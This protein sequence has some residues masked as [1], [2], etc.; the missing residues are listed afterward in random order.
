MGYAV[1][2]ADIV[3]LYG[4]QGVV[5]FPRDT[6]GDPAAEL[7]SMRVLHEV[8]LPHDD[9]FLSRMDVKDPAQ[10]SALLGEFLAS[11]ER[12][13]PSG[14][15]EWPVLG[16]FQDSLLA[17]DPVTGRVYAFPEGTGRHLCIH[18]NVESLIYSLCALQEYTRER[19]SSEDEEALAL[20]TRARI[21]AFDRIPFED[22]ASEWNI[23]FGE[24]MEGTW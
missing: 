23:I 14:A 12:P 20:R 15:E 24:I 16:Y 17:F 5:L 11:V 18:R 1:G 4:L 19:D 10:D 8:G 21:E 2:T 9:L 22:P 6:H 7:P 3:R 13:C